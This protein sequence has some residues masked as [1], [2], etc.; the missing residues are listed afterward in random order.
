MS[1]TNKEAQ[2]YSIDLKD[3]LLQ[4]RTKDPEFMK[5]PIHCL[6]PYIHKNTT[7]KIY[8]KGHIVY[9]QINKGVYRIE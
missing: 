7:W 1:N 3:M 8:N 9:I 2:F 4:T 5:V 6:L